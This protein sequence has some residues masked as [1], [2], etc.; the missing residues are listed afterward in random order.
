LQDY[1]VKLPSISIE[2]HSEAEAY[3]LV[4]MWLTT[5]LGIFPLSNGTII[6][7]ITVVDLKTKSV[8]KISADNKFN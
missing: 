3:G 4:M 5:T 6:E 1:L 2:A 8:P 7:P